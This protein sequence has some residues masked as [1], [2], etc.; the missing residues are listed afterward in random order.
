MHIVYG[1]QDSRDNTVFYVGLTAD[2]YTRYV[3]HIRCE[4]S[5]AEK[6]ERIHQLKALGLLPLPLTLETVHTLHQGQE[7]ELYW[8]HHYAYLGMPLTNEIRPS[9]AR[10]LKEMRGKQGKDISPL[11]LIPGPSVSVDDLPSLARQ[12]MSLQAAGVQKTEIMRQVWG[13]NPGGSQEYRAAQEKYQ[14]V[15]Q[16]IASQIGA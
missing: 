14:A 7:R 10:R 9:M 13:V 8:I 2:L 5:N 6:N 3:Q 12:V 15:M 4:G 16:F 1:L 11:K